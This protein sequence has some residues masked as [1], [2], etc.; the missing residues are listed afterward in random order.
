MNPRFPGKGKTHENYLFGHII[1]CHELED[2]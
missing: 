1:G 2:V